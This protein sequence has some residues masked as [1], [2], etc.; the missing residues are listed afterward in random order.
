MR[1]HLW[2]VLG[3]ALVLVGGALALTTQEAPEDF[4]WFAYTPGGNPSWFAGE[5]RT[6]GWS[7]TFLVSRAQLAGTGLAALGLLALAAGA[8]FRFG[9]RRAQQPEG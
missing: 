4:G 3:L 8:G 5:D 2:W 1:R 6:G 7:S 9:R